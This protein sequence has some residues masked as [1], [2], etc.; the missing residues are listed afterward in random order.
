MIS[1]QGRT[2]HFFSVAELVDSSWHP[3]FYSVEFTGQRCS[4]VY[5]LYRGCG[6]GFQVLFSLSCH[7]YKCQYIHYLLRHASSIL[8]RF[9]CGLSSGNSA[10]NTTIWRHYLW[11]RRYLLNFSKMCQRLEHN[12]NNCSEHILVLRDILGTSHD[13][14]TSWTLDRLRLYHRHRRL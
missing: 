14:V 6:L 7:P 12:L 1:F 3:S 2:Q 11:F 5:L 13:P 8:F 10:N 4:F 9:A